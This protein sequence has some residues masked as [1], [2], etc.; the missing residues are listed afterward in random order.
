MTTA[1]HDSKLDFTRTNYQRLLKLVIEKYQPTTF[2]NFCRQ[3]KNTNFAIW[4]HDIDC[5]PQAALAFGKIEASL[6]VKATYYFNMRCYFYNLF[7][8]QVQNIVAELHS[9]G[10]EIGLHFDAL[11]SDISTAHKLEKS[12]QNEK[13]TFETFFGF[14]IKSFSFHNPTE[15]TSA[16]KLDSYADLYNAYSE[17]LM[18]SLPYCSDSNGHWRFTS[19]ENFL[20]ANH[21]SIYV[22]THPEWWTELVMSPRDRIVRCVEGRASSTLKQYDQQMERDG[23]ANIRK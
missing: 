21:E 15:V 13:D 16:Y 22:L 6:G 3:D 20:L 17:K 14:P 8:S 18:S 12:L 5:S 11:Q 23:R 10:H 9:M 7:E 19:L 1:D 4:R 2:E